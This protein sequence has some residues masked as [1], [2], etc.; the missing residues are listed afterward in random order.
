MAILLVIFT[1]ESRCESDLFFFPDDQLSLAV[2]CLNLP[3]CERSDAS[4]NTA[5][6]RELKPPCHL[7]RKGEWRERIYPSGIVS[8]SRA[9]ETRIP[10]AIIYVP[11]WR[12]QPARV[13]MLLTVAPFIFFPHACG[14]F[15]KPSCCLVQ[16]RPTLYMSSWNCNRQQYRLLGL[17]WQTP[18]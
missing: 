14:H 4:E 3:L 10:F 12:R 7:L 6:W 15:P 17:S 2:I 1:V 5:C 11:R 9:L 18:P 13:A 16:S 8:Q